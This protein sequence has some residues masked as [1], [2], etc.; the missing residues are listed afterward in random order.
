MSKEIRVSEKHGVNP[1]MGVCWVC[2][3]EDGTIGLL[4]RLPGDKEAPRHAVISDEPCATC[5]G[6]IRDGYVALVPMIGD[7]ADFSPDAEGFEMMLR[8]RDWKTTTGWIARRKWSL[9]FSTEPPPE[10][11]DIAFC[12]PG[13]IA[14]LVRMQRNAEMQEAPSN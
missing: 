14:A 8:Q 4:G 11:T 1:T 3:A 10:N 2:G 12:D 9:I 13:V 5:K 7:I 6:H